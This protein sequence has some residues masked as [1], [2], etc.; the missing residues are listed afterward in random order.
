MFNKFTYQSITVGIKY[1]VLDLLCDVSNYARPAKWRYASHTVND[2]SAVSG[3]SSL[4]HAVN[5][6][7]KPSFR[8][9]FMKNFFHFHIFCFFP[10]FNHTFSYSYVDFTRI[11]ASNTATDDVTN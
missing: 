9:R 4:E 5:S 2:D 10:V 1:F 11:E 6:V 3:I 8:W 7:P